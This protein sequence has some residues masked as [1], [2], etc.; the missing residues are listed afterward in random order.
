MELSGLCGEKNLRQQPNA[1][2]S[3]P[4][5]SCINYQLSIINYQLN[6]NGKEFNLGKDS[7]H[8]YHCAYRHRH[9]L[10]GDLVHGSVR[11]TKWVRHHIGTPIFL[12]E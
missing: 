6:K 5:P 11:K 1:A 7:P 9:H 10:R 3:V 4:T 8:R 12:L 2:R